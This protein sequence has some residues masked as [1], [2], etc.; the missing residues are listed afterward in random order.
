M[1]LEFSLPPTPNFSKHCY[2]MASPTMHNMYYQMKDES[3]MN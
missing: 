1:P 2:H 3:I